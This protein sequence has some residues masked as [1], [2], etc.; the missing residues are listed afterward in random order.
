MQNLVDLCANITSETLPTTPGSA[1]EAAVE[2]TDIV[3]LLFNPSALRDMIRLR[4]VCTT[5][6]RSAFPVPIPSLAHLEL[7]TG[8][9]ENYVAGAGASL[10][11]T[12]SAHHALAMCG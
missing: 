4:S 1:E 5:T 8:V 3:N 7:P 10:V 2:L 9:V 11:S 6:R 12:A